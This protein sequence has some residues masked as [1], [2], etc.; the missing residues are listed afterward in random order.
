VKRSN[1][2]GMSKYVYNKRLRKRHNIAIWVLLLLLCASGAAYW[3]DTRPVPPPKIDVAQATPLPQAKQVPEPGDVLQEVS[4]Q[5][6]TPAQTEALAKENYGAVTP[7]I[8]TG[9]TK[10]TFR[11]R[12]ELPD[13]TFVPVYARAYLPDD[14]KKNLP[15]FAFAPG[16]TGIGDECAAS[17]EDVAKANWGNYD[18]HMAL[19][20]S[21]GYAAVTTDYEGMRDPTRIHHYMVGEL[22]GRAVLDSIRGLEQLSETQGRLNPKDVFLAGYSQGGHAAFWADKIAAS[23]SPEIKPLGVVGF[24]PVMSVTQTLTD[25]VHGANI[26]WFGPYVLFSYNSYYGHDYGD[27]LLPHWQATLS[28]DVQ[29]HCINTDIQ[30]WGNKPENVY[31]PGFIQAAQT[32]TLSTAFPTLYQDMEANAVGADSTSTAKLINSGQED[33]VVL[34]TQQIAEANVLCQS[35]T[36][37]V[38]LHIY[39]KTTHYNTMVNSLDD[40]LAWMRSLM[41]G[42]KVA[43]T[44][45][46]S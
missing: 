4:V 14:P 27:V 46:V 26:D 15:I 36:G 6:F 45:P 8:T 40:T 37:P 13:G 32:G 39:P 28:Q 31:T 41:K 20:A 17:L 10:I 22:E 16:T 2:K 18:S 21:Q 35:S 5:Y 25:V 43:S 34:P 30:F 38:Y 44:C 1:S 12:S 9:V 7:A 42:E 24:G 3:W 33:N 29:S 23:Y 19:Y 11:Y